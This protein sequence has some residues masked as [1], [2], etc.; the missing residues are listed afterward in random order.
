MSS[1]STGPGTITIS[2]NGA[3]N[4]VYDGIVRTGPLTIA[5]INPVSTLTAN[6][7]S[8]GNTISN[9][10]NYIVL[11]SANITLDGQNIPVNVSATSYPGFLQ[12]NKQ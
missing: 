6:F 5:N 11:N 4:F 8:Q 1:I 12:K 7:D 9:T 2:L 3:G 10:S